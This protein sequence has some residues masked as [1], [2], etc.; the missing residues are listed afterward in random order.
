MSDDIQPPKGFEW[1]MENEPQ[2]ELMQWRDMPKT[3]AFLVYPNDDPPKARRRV[4]NRIRQ[5]IK[6]RNIESSPS[7]ERVMSFSFW[8]WVAKTYPTYPLP[9]DKHWLRQGVENAA[10]L[11]WRNDGAS[12]AEQVIIEAAKYLPDNLAHSLIALFRRWDA[13]IADLKNDLKN[14]QKQA[15]LAFKK[16]DESLKRE[17]EWRSKLSAAGRKGGKSKGNW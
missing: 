8:R 7:G 10:T 13:T 16:R 1:L 2:N 3:I 9:F 12:E 5:A 17:A 14:M 4:R 15:E 6:K 11:G